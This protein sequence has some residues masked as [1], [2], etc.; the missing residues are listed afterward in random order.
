MWDKTK[1]KLLKSPDIWWFSPDPSF[2]NAP[3]GR[4][5]R[6][7]N[8]TARVPS[9]PW[10]RRFT[11]MRRRPLGKWW[12]MCCGRWQ[13]TGSQPHSNSSRVT[14]GGRRILQ[15]ESKASK[16]TDR[17]PQSRMCLLYSLML[18][19]NWATWTTCLY[20]NR[21]VSQHPSSSSSSSSLHLKLRSWSIKSQM[22]W[23]EKC[24]CV[25]SCSQMVKKIT[26][27]FFFLKSFPWPRWKE[28]WCEFRRT[29]CLF[30]SICADVQKNKQIFNRL[31][32]VAYDVGL[33]CCY[34]DGEQEVINDKC[35]T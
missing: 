13:Q 7:W 1:C 18:C 8:R 3:R 16:Y 15:G 22:V 9:T 21:N 11:Q 10:T 27:R 30:R 2:V 33:F 6:T 23:I 32:G 31:S 5:K 14:C 17:F 24:V 20:L 28:M 35:D 29:L 12:I 34:A 19:S 25:Q 4:L 26:S